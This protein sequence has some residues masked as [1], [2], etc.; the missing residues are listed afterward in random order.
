ML[1]LSQGNVASFLQRGV[2]CSK[3]FV[4]NLLPSHKVKYSVS[5]S[6]TGDV[7][8]KNIVTRLVTNGSVLG[9]IACM[10]LQLIDAAYC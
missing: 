1:N 3:E 6:A 8:D 9:H 7:T 4:R 10:Q 5:K 2:I